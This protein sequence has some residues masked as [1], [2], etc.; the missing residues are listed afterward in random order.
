MQA[1]SESQVIWLYRGYQD[2][3][4]V[5]GRIDRGIKQ[6]HR[7]DHGP[8]LL[9]SGRFLLFFEYSKVVPGGKV[10]YCLPI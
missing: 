5:E 9:A 6:Q 7:S 4:P 2:W 3:R 1:L 10:F 8:V